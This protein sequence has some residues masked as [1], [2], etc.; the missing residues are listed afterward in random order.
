METRSGARR[1][2]VIAI[3][4]LVACAV[5]A[6]CSSYRLKADADELSSVDIDALTHV[7]VHLADGTVVEDVLLW[8]DNSSLGCRS[9]VFDI[10]SIDYVEWQSESAGR[11]QVNWVTALAAVA[12]ITVVALV[13]EPGHWILP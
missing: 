11:P 9:H 4:P 5:L 7:R 12:L 13:W 1:R 2:A 3:L 8:I 6:A 10:E